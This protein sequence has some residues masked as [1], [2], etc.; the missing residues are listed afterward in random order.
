V[1]GDAKPRVVLDTNVFVAAGFNRRSRSAQ[2]IRRIEQGRVA[3]VWHQA[4]R[5]ETERIL[6]QIP[7]LSWEDVAPLFTEKGEYTG[8]IAPDAFPQVEDA[9]DR[10]FAALSAASG[11]ILVTNDDH[12]LAPRAIL[13]IEI[14]TPSEFMER[15]GAIA[16]P[17]T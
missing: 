6:R 13:G 3:F 2:I 10:K 5:R 1:S 17:P 14:L 16:A 9:D 4:T 8:A 7:L 11:S 15:S 12:L